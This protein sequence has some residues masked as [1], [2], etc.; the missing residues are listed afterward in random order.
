MDLFSKLFSFFLKEHIKYYKT[1]PSLVW[2]DF[3]LRMREKIIELKTSLEKSMEKISSDYGNG[4]VNGFNQE[5]LG[6]I[7]FK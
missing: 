5:F 3:M 6:G 4:L 2:P 1:L 7:Y